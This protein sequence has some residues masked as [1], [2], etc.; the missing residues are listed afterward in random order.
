[1]TEIFVLQYIKVIVCII[2][3]II[4]CPCVF[5]VITVVFVVRNSFLIASSSSEIDVDFCFAIRKILDSI[6]NIQWELETAYW[7]SL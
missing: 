7:R 2:I 6:F 1:M 4:L 5:F 3:I